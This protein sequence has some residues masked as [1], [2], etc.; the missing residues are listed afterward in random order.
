VCDLGLAVHLGFQ[1]PRLGCECTLSPLE[2]APPPPILIEP[3]HARQ[4]DL[5][6]PLDLLPDARLPAPEPVPACLEFLR[7]PVAAM[8]PLEGASD[9]RRLGEQ[10]A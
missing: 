9:S 7:E 3:D 5:G 1:L 2:V 4:V 6:Q 8:G 10:A